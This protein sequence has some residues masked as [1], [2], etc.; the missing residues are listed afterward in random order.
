[1]LHQVDALLI[2]SDF[3]MSKVIEITHTIRASQTSQRITI[4]YYY[5]SNTMVSFD[6]LRA[7]GVDFFEAFSVRDN[8]QDVHVKHLFKSLS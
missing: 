2:A 7:A 1:M 3:S 5:D 4:I 8:N 6:E